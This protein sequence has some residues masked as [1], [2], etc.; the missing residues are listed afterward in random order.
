M[1][2]IELRTELD[3]SCEREPM[4]LDRNAEIARSM[5][6]AC[7]IIS[8]GWLDLPRGDMVL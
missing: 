4:L 8:R 6:M 3:C 7:H 5:V 1:S 2:L